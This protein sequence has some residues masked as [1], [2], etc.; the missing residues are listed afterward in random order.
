MGSLIETAGSKLARVSTI[1]GLA[2][3][4]DPF[5]QDRKRRINELTVHINQATREG[6]ETVVIK[7]IGE[8]GKPIYGKVSVA[9]L[10]KIRFGQQLYTID[11][12][13]TQGKP[14]E[15]AIKIVLGQL[16]DNKPRIQQK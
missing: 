5:M 3:R 6:Q 8:D 13:V 4:V 1:T 10:R 12:L 11:D 7:R 2:K 15:E 14:Q 9:I 16:E